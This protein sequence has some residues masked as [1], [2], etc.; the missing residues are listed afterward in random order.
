MCGR[1]LVGA[2]AEAAHADTF[3]ECLNICDIVSGC[4]GVTFLLQVPPPPVAQKNC[5]PYRNVVDYQSPAA[6]GALLSG[7]TSDRT[8]LNNTF[9][10]DPICP[11]DRNITDAFGIQYAIGCD[12]N[13][14]GTDVAPTVTQSLNGCLL[15]CSNF[16]GCVAV[17]YLGLPAPFNA[18]LGRALNCYPNLDTGSPESITSS[19]GSS[20]AKRIFP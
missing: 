18:S 12:K 7:V 14:T 19:P 11:G 13:I 20:Y 10:Y 1:D 16:G 8:I 5:H 9:S 3:D 4:E 15:Y 2:N 17:N 6:V